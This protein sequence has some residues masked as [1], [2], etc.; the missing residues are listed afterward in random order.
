[1]TKVDKLAMTKYNISIEEMMENA[2]R[3]LARFISELKPKPKKIIILFGKGNNGGGGLVAARHLLIYDFNVEIISASKEINKNVRHQL[4]ILS[5]LNI[6]PK[7]SFKANKG[8]VIIDA[9]IGYN[10]KGAP[11][12]R[13]ADLIKGIN[14]MKKSGLKVVS[15]DI[16]SGVDPNKGII[17]ETY[18]KA[19]YTLTLALPK[20]GLKKLKNVFLVNIGIPNKV[21]SELGIKTKNHFKDKDVV[22]IQ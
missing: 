14:F 9:L 5:K 16:P 1:M 6:K 7:I 15:L 22:K 19:N 10:L 4:K 20:K 2:G 17:R 11:R 13:F 12:K 8:D 18:V 21:Y 3:N